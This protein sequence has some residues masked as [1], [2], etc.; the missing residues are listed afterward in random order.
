MIP[1]I[2]E[3]PFSVILSLAFPHALRRFVIS[4]GPTSL[5]RL[6]H[7]LIVSLTILAL[8]VPKSPYAEIN[9][10]ALH[11]PASVMP[12][13]LRASLSISNNAASVKPE[14]WW[15]KA[16]DA[17][18][19]PVKSF[20]AFLLTLAMFEVRLILLFLFLSLVFNTWSGFF[21]PAECAIPNSRAL[22]LIL[23]IRL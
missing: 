10:H 12:E 4:S 3:S 19:D 14:P 23:K 2:W 6:N 15:P 21:V 9:P 8:G 1:L 22:L 11:L 7:S 17:K 13:H 18:P 16:V 5:S 20:L